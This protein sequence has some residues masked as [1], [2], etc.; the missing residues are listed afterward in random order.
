MLE[1]LNEGLVL[2]IASNE[3]SQLSTG[4]VVEDR[5]TGVDVHSTAASPTTPSSRRVSVP[6]KPKSNKKKKSS[7]ELSF[8]KSEKIALN[9][10]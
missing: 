1:K 4:G 7:V 10:F 8:L 6:S 9:I 3:P 5:T 2:Q